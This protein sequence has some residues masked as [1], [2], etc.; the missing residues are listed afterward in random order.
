MFKVEFDTAGI[1]SQV[2]KL[3]EVIEGAIRPAA[4]AGA[5]VYYDEMRLRAGAIKGSGKLARSVFQKYVKELSAP[6][7]RARYH[8]SWNKGK[9]TATPYAPH[10]QLI[11]YGW[12]Q[13]YASYIGSNG[14]WYTEVRPE[15]RGKPKPKRSAPQS[16]KDAYYVLRK[17]GPIQH[18]PRS[19][20]R[21]TYEAKNAE[22]AAAVNKEMQERILKAFL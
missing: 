20:L 7:Q 1:T 14:H 19:F 18:A 6:G 22:A 8:I 5:Q 13:R 17:G 16:V 10:G 9:G 3:H 2:D 4:Q 15:M 11:E 12:I 21:A